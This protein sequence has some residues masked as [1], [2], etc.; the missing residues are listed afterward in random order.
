M[1]EAQ[2]IR[3]TGFLYLE[4]RSVKKRNLT[5]RFFE[6]LADAPPWSLEQ[7]DLPLDEDAAREVSI[8]IST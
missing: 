7:L 4:P 2:Q 3:A 8:E 1:V 6:G 5:Y